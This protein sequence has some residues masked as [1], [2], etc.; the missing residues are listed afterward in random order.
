MDIEKN[1]SM[2]D[3]FMI[4]GLDSK[5]P[6]IDIFV[7]LSREFKGIKKLTFIHNPNTYFSKNCKCQLDFVNNEC[8]Q[9]AKNH[10]KNS[11]ISKI[12]KNPDNKLL[13][14]KENKPLHNNIIEESVNSTN[15]LMFE[16]LQINHINILEFIDYLQKYINDNSNIDSFKITKIRQYANRILVIFDNGVPDCIKT[17][18]RKGENEYLDNVPYF[19]YK[20]KNIPIIPKMKPLCNVGKYK[21]KNLKISTQ[22]LCEE[23]KENLIK[24]FDG[25]YQES[26]NIKRMVDIAYNNLMNKEKNRDDRSA[27]KSGR[28]RSRDR[29]R[30]W[31]RENRERH[32]KSSDR[33]R[34]NS[35]RRE[36]DKEY[37]HRRDKMEHSSSR[38]DNNNKNL[39]RQR[40]DNNNINF[41]F[42]NDD[43]NNGLNN[44][45]GLNINE[46][47]INQVTALF[48]NSNALNLLQYL[49]ENNLINT[50]NNNNN[51]NNNISN[52]NNM[53]N[54]IN[55]NMSNNKDNNINSFSCLYNQNNLNNLTNQQ[56]INLLQQQNMISN[57]AKNNQQGNLTPNN[58]GGSFGNMMGMNSMMNNNY[59]NNPFP[60]NVNEQLMNTFSNFANQQSQNK[61]S[62]NK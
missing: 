25:N 53:N 49:I 42:G 41:N 51:M 31:S 50:N 12:L 30:S 17:Y 4:T 27:K 14:I 11:P 5:T 7:L 21:E 16:N 56:L 57:N 40:N 9:I 2:V 43:N 60:F 34:D 8:Y 62:G 37:S 6:L 26:N 10:L 61:D 23:D 33:N 19:D 39:D 3:S 46:N 35:K 15:A 52:N 18:I 38:N 58:L 36:K 13:S 44:L 47:D 1:D 54:N 48:K 32:K 59:F 22:C 24:I 45:K 29:D 55:N 20:G 28:K